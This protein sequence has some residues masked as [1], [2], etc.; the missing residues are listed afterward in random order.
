MPGRGIFGDKPDN[1]CI[2]ASRKFIFL[3]IDQP[4]QIQRKL[5]MEIANLNAFCIRVGFPENAISRKHKKTICIYGSIRYYQLHRAVQ[6]E[7]QHVERED[8]CIY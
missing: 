4:C 8:L 2:C 5:N 6:Q 3:H 1:P 7:Q